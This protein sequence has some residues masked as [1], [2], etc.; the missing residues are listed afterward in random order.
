[1]EL[2]FLYDNK[3]KDLCLPN[4]QPPE[5]LDAAIRW[6]IEN[7]STDGGYLARY[8]FSEFSNDI[9]VMGNNMGFQILTTKDYNK[10]YDIHLN[11]H[12]IDD[13]VKNYESHKDKK[14]YYILEPFGHIDFFKN[15]YA[16]ISYGLFEKI[17][18]L[19]A[20]ILI[21]Y[22]HEGH[23][24]EFFILE[25]LK[26]LKYKKVIF[27]YNDYLND[28]SNIASRNIKFVPFNYYLN[29]SSKYFQQHL[30]DNSITEL[31]DMNEKQFHFLSFNQWLHHHRTNIISTIFNKKMDSKFLISFNPKFYDSL[32]EDTKRDYENEIKDLGF[33]DDYQYVLTLPEHRVDFDTTLKISGYG[34]EDISVY[35]KSFISLISDTIFFKKQGFI[36]E[37]I[38]KPIMY[39]QP[40]LIA[41]PPLY[42]KAIREMG[43]KTFDGFIDESYDLEFDDMK[44]LK[45][46]NNEIERICNISVEDMKQNLKEIEDVLI[47]N[48]LKLLTFD[49]EKSEVDVCEEILNEKHRYNIL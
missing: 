42:L 6:T 32:N 20:T 49:F 41:G 13:A 23:L 33:W 3:I 45:L 1:M 28:F 21:N 40:F 43:F 11:T 10:K 30:R 24:N 29:R 5:V 17:K 27:I 35:R 38:F 34:Y 19:N 39:L 47:Y 8:L 15:K 36:S 14:F 44:R 18:K 46:I 31:L 2:N 26:K 12:Q 22:S 9:I 16:G 48:Q 4:G 25:I 37:K 7:N